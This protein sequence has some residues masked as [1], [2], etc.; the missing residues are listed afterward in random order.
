VP[1]EG[2]PKQG[3]ARAAA[4]A[5]HAARSGAAQLLSIAC[6][7]LG[8]IYSILAA[9]LFGLIVF[10]VFQAT[11]AVIEV[12]SRMGILGGT[13][14]QQ[15][16]ISRH[17]AAGETELELRA[18]GTGIRFALGAS[19]LL[20]VALCLFAGWVA[21]AYHDPRLSVS[22]RVMAPAIFFSAL[23]AV[24]VAATYGAK[25]ARMNLYVRGIA[26]PLLLLVASIV[27]WAVSGSLFALAV[28]YVIASGGTA[29]VAVITSGRVFGVARLKAA[30]RA[31]RHP[32][33]AAFAL[34]LA[35]ADVMTIVLQKTDFILVTG[36]L[37]PEALGVYAAAEFIARAIANARYVFDPIAAPILSEAL[38]ARDPARLRYNLR[39]MTRWVITAA[40]PL[41]VTVIVLRDMLLGL[42][43]KPFREGAASLVILA[44]AQLVSASLGLTPY[45][46][47][48]GGRSRLMLVN[49]LGAALLNMALEVL[50]IP[51][52]GIMGA[53][54][55]VLVSITALQVGMTIQTWFIERVHPFSWALSKPI[56]ATIVALGVELVTQRLPL[57]AITRSCAAAAA[58]LSTYG[59]ILI[60]LGLPAEENRL[61]MRIKARIG[62]T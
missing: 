39:L 24:L 4:D 25:V 19:C 56:L 11:L 44:V 35:V 28:A 59:F 58:G 7:L 49:Q 13:G 38:H 62:L 34:P 12:L 51:R 9:R 8:P 26:E 29:A 37:G 61:Y 52:M 40:A 48:M 36:F 23:T 6:Q 54:V 43:G 46:L 30:L 3:D 21:R 32:S 41:F 31:P 22:L 45:V 18:L 27:A 50:L 17:R 2:D 57:P 55:A 5:A 20:A 60:L 53:A 16:F 15:L 1:L 33:Y 10:G 42:Y 14:G 47:L